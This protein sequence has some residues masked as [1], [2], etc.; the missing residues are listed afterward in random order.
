MTNLPEEELKDDRRLPVAGV[1]RAIGKDAQEWASS[2]QNMNKANKGFAGWIRKRRPVF[3]GV[4]GSEST[5]FEFARAGDDDDEESSESEEDEDGNSYAVAE[6]VVL[7]ETLETW[8]WAT[9][10]DDANKNNGIVDACL[11][12]PRFAARD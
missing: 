4:H 6:A 2:S 8:I 10:D 1:L 12:V 11:E 7:L 3:G 9:D 5:S